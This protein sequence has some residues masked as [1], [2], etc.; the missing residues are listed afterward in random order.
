MRCVFSIVFI[1]F[2]MVGAAKNP[3]VEWFKRIIPSVDFDTIKKQVVE[4]IAP[5]NST[6]NGLE[7]VI[8]RDFLLGI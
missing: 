8:V 1:Y 4:E 6:E 2:F 7:K 5:Q 3:V